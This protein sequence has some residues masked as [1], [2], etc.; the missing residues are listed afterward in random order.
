VA[1]TNFVLIKITQVY[2]YGE[3]YVGLVATV[4][5]Q[6]KDYTHSEIGIDVG[7]K[8]FVALSDGQ[9]L[10]S[11]KYLRQAEKRL[12]QLQR[13]LSRKKMGS[14]NRR[15]AKYLLAIQHKK[16]ANKRRDFL[17][18]TSFR[19]VKY[20]KFIAV[21]N[22]HVKNMIKNH[23]LAKCFAD[24]SWGKFICMLEHKSALYGR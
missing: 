2:S 21:E 16:V 10:A 3:W 23:K 5:I 14:R 19:I 7:I 17:H 24:S 15:R 22:L 6:E 12:K 13:R 1:Y 4:T 8:R 18:K 11:P 9:A 20:C